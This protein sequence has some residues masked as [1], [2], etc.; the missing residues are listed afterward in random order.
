MGN[1]KERQAGQRQS[2]AHTKARRKYDGGWTAGGAQRVTCHRVIRKT[3]ENLRKRWGKASR[4][5]SG[6]A[7]RKGRAQRVLCHRVMRKS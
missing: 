6:Q 4:Q 2:R 5:A 1:A 3:Q 7:G